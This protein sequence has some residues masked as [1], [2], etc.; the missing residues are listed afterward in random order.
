MQGGQGSERSFVSE[1]QRRWRWTSFCSCSSNCQRLCFGNCTW[2]F[3]GVK[4]WTLSLLR[5]N[6]NCIQLASF[7]WKRN[8]THT[9]VR[10]QYRLALQNIIHLQSFKSSGL[11]RSKHRLVL[12]DSVQLDRRSPYIEPKPPCVDPLLCR[13][14]SCQYYNMCIPDEKAR[15]PPSVSLASFACLPSNCIPKHWFPGVAQG[16]RVNYFWEVQWCTSETRAFVR[17]WGGE[18]P[19]S[20]VKWRWSVRRGKVGSKS[21]CRRRWTN[22]SYL[23]PKIDSLEWSDY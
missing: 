10:S 21:P 23:E 6:R 13:Q 8:Y 2:D 14:I 1:S 3:R 9:N 15:H 17:H 7:E 18:N 22:C 12:W 5:L 19:I 4:R 20:A 16:L 11:P